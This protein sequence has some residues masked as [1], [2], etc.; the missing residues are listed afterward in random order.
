MRLFNAG[1]H[2]W[3]NRLLDSSCP[4]VCMYH[5][6]PGCADFHEILYW[7]F[8][9]SLIEIGQK[10][11]ALTSTRKYSLSFPATFNKYKRILLE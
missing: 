9:D 8:Y 6:G 2:R 3:G 1:S 10:Y 4:F 11:Q 5:R 7:D